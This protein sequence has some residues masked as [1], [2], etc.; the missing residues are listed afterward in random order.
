[1]T[2]RLRTSTTRD[3][4]PPPRHR[5]DAEEKETYGFSGKRRYRRA[6]E[7]DKP[8]KAARADASSSEA[9]GGADVSA[10]RTAEE[11]TSRYAEGM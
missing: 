8:P 1:M 11:T 7:R 6:A 3:T 9:K 10:G 4:G 5:Y 2:A